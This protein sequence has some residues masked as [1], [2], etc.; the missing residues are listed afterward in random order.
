[1]FFKAMQKRISLFVLTLVLG[2]T[3]KLT[4]APGLTWANNG[5]DG[6]DLITA[7]ATGGVAHPSGYPLY[8]L[9]AGLF[10]RLPIGS[11]AL[12]TNLMSAV[13]T[14]IAATMIFWFLEQRLNSPYSALV[15]ALAFGLSPLV[16]SQAV[17][18]E[19][20]TLHALLTTGIICMLLASVQK[21]FFYMGQGLL[22][23]L[24]IGNHL[25]TLLLL[26]LL[27]LIQH[28]GGKGNKI[29]R[30]VSGWT[31]LLTI[32]LRLLGVLIGLLVYI[33]LPLR[34]SAGPPVSWGNPVTLNNFLGLVSAQ[35]YR[36]YALSL[37][38][39]EI[40]Q[41]FQ[42]LGGLLFHQF[43]FI[44]L[45]F[46]IYGL[47]SK[48]GS[49]IR[50]STIWVFMS[51]SFFA[52]LYAYADSFVYVIP[53]ILAFSIWIGYGLQDI[54]TLY[55]WRGNRVRLA[56]FLALLAGIVVRSL[57]L[58]PEV[59][60]S[61]DQR[62]EIFGENVLVSAPKDAF[63]FT[64]SDE[65]T[66]ALWYFHYALRQR[67]DLIVVAEGLLQYDWYSQILKN[68]YSELV[69]PDSQVFLTP[70][71]IADANPS[72]D[73]CFANGTGVDVLVCEDIISK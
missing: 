68:T 59:D 27:L 52:V 46:G 62:A 56:F 8:L 71:A 29:S 73:A 1:M 4:L 18:T 32:S 61:K 53:A 28:E 67:Q 15:G 69:I 5:A 16:W 7:A 14:I 57:W 30:E 65:E 66:F 55:T 72:H 43:T 24:A 60:A 50:L 19:V 17:I 49:A 58:L 21:P 51:F 10:Q 45:F 11:L 39:L 25:T 42:G 54:F 48:M 41:R 35:A 37:S 64:D 31:R 12:R 70:Q 26:P 40:V 33:V 6:G 63:V 22:F 34:A 9:L 36:R 38:A 2:L 47:F 44:G 13:F 20:Y 23:G 3:Y